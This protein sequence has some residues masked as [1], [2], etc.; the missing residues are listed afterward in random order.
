MTCIV[1][2]I[3]RKNRGVIIGG[4]SAG[5]DGHVNTPRKD[6]KVFRIDDFI[7]GATTS[8]RMLQLIRYSFVPPKPDQKIGF[9]TAKMSEDIF[10]FMCTDFV[11]ALRHC[12]KKGGFL[13]QANGVEFGGGFIVAYKDRLFSIDRDF[14]VAESLE[15]FTSVGAGEYFALAA[16]KAL[17]ENTELSPILIARK[18]LEVTAHYST[19]VRQPFNFIHSNPNI[20]IPE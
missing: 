19:V 3:D 14:Q 12:F 18:A 2:I 7:F 4:D 8:F 9:G 15:E 20:G 11:D 10:R 17:T 16:M 1:G 6:E 5:S 13:G